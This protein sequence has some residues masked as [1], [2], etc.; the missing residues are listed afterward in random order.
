MVSA[1][2]SSMLTTRNYLTDH[3]LLGMTL[4]AYNFIGEYGKRLTIGIIKRERHN[5]NK[6]N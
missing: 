1:N 3:K 6:A 5:K 4:M 2:L